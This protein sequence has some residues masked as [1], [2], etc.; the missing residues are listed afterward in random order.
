MTIYTHMSIFFN[1]ISDLDNIW[2]LKYADHAI[3]AQRD[4]IYRAVI[5]S[6]HLAH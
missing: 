2:S 5:N 1:Q 4:A 6:P 3:A